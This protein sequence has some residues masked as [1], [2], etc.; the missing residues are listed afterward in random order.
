MSRL[1]PCC[2]VAS[3]RLCRSC[4]LSR[5]SAYPHHT[6]VHA[7]GPA[8]TLPLNRS[9]EDDEQWSFIVR[10]SLD[11]HGTRSVQ[12]VLEL[13][14]GTDDEPLAAAALLSEPGAVTRLACDGNGNH[15]ISRALTL[16]SA[17]HSQA[18][19]AVVTDH[20]MEISRHRHGCAVVQRSL[21]VARGAQRARLL[22][23]VG[24]HCL[25]MMVDPFANY[26]IQHAVGSLPPSEV[27][28]LVRATRGFAVCLALQKYASNVIERCLQH[29]EDGPRGEL[30]EELACLAPSRALPPRIAAVAM[31]GATHA[32]AH[33]G[34]SGDGGEG[35]GGG[36]A[37]GRH[38]VGIGVVPPTVAG[39]ASVPATAAATPAPAPAAM[40]AAAADGAA[41]DIGS[42]GGEDSAALP[43]SDAST[44]APAA[45]DA[46]PPPS[47]AP[48]TAA[49]PAAAPASPPASVDPDAP[50]PFHADMSAALAVLLLDPFGK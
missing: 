10:C 48:D 32:G 24:A 38:V 28:P 37:G 42:A 22:A 47:D 49:A 12:K 35:G 45:A 7:H 9:I 43:T 34:G 41:A 5:T 15:V 25:E 26:V 46:S 2:C 4:K 27:A 36:G 13:A 1:L 14:A 30:I 50:G 33:H 44:G 18:V 8:A 6:S 29:A 39:A 3:F 40:E 11:L 16:L 23:A 31:C 17:P 21:E 20:L 19:A